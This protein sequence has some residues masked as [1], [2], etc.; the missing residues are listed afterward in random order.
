MIRYKVSFIKYTRSSNE[1]ISPFEELCDVPSKKVA[2]YRIE[3]MLNDI[4][5]INYRVDNSEGDWEEAA[6]DHPTDDIWYRF[7]I[8]EENR[9]P[10]DI[11]KE[12]HYFIKAMRR[13]VAFP[14]MPF[15]LC[16]ANDTDWTECIIREDRYKVDDGYKVTLVPIDQRFAHEDY[17]QSDFVSLMKSGHIVKKSP[18]TCIEHITFAESVGC[19]LYVITEA[20][21]V[22]DVEE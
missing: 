7:L 14:G 19:G 3:K 20:N 1:V 8:T 21:I 2:Y 15:C 6:F 17:Y 10:Y 16:D 12:A 22:S 5:G 4:G 13:G 18:T 9:N 11:D